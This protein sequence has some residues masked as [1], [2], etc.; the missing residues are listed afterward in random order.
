[1]SAFSDFITTATAPWWSPLAGV[2]G[3]AVLNHVLTIQRENQAQTRAEK[4]KWDKEILELSSDVIT[5]ANQLVN[6]TMFYGR[7]IEPGR[8]A[9][10]NTE[11]IIQSLTETIQRLGLIA[12]VLAGPAQ[13]VFNSTLKYFNQ[14]IEDHDNESQGYKDVASARN[15]FDQAV[16][17]A[18]KALTE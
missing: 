4:S 18:L 5:Q 6:P 17:E 8:R 10:L 14:P 16:G 15:E 11:I 12:P 2:L 13:R 7:Y 9:A 1:M 3:G